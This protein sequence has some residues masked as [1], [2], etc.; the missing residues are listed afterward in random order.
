MACDCICSFSMWPETY[1]YLVKKSYIKQSGMNIGKYFRWGNFIANTSNT[2]RKHTVRENREYRTTKHS[3]P[4][5]RQEHI[6]DSVLTENI[7]ICRKLHKK[8]LNRFTN[9][10]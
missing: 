3:T 9:R 10:A 8:A 2:V 4:I 6:H 1:K 5:I 7:N